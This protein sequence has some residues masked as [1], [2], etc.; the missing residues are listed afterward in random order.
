MTAN[1]IKVLLLDDPCVSS[2]RPVLCGNSVH[3]H[4]K[5][6]EIEHLLQR[7]KTNKYELSARRPF[8]MK[9]WTDQDAGNRN[10]AGLR[11]CISNNTSNSYNK[12]NQIH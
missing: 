3:G 5:N 2:W 8:V 7:W 9:E 11:A 6:K 4:N 1:L 12:T 10:H